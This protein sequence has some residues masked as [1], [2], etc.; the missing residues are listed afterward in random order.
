MSA[1]I[2]LFFACCPAAVAGLVIAIVVDAVK[3]GSGW[4]YA[5]IG[6]EIYKGEPPFANGDAPTSVALPPIAFL[7]ETS[8]LHGRPRTIGWGEKMLSWRMA[9]ARL[10]FGQVFAAKTPAT[11]NLPFHK[12]GSGDG[13]N[14]VP[15]RANARP[16]SML[17]LYVRK[18]LHRQAAEDSSCQLEAS[19][20]V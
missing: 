13:G 7:V 14:F 12:V 5:H 18:V 4:A 9:M 10:Y 8:G 2:H 19:G 15:A 11:R 17:F 1:V 16:S 3:S 20:H 6:E